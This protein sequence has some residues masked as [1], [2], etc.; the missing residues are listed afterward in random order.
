MKPEEKSRQQ[1]DQ[2][3]EPAGRKVQDFRELNLG[4][5]LGVAVREPKS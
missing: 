5:S 4:A 3:L 2:L 1:I